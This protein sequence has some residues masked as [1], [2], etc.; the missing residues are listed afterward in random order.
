MLVLAIA[1]AACSNNDYVAPSNPPPPPPTTPPP[2]PPA[3]VKLIFRVQPG[4][5]VAGQA[6]SPAIEVIE[7]DS[8]G[9]LQPWS[10]DTITV[11]IEANNAGAVLSGTK[12]IV[13][14]RGVA[15]FGDLV[16][17]KAGRFAITAAA[18]GVGSVTSSEFTV[19]QPP[20]VR[21]KQ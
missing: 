2:P 6:I 13:A 20:T 12:T 1:S 3:A 17:D 8:A 19:A 16:V 9:T 4:A 21:D 15:S 5:T 7:T 10:V 11:A 18:R 14:N